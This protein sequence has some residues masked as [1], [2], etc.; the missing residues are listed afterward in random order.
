MTHDDH[1]REQMG[2]PPVHRPS[3][4]Q[5]LEWYQEWR[6]GQDAELI[7][8]S[9]FYDALWDVAWHVGPVWVLI[10]GTHAEHSSIRVGEHEFIEREGEDR[11]I[12]WARRLKEPREANSPRPEPPETT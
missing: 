12:E 11:L 6:A 8:R 5:M 7:R 1:L 10:A 3:D 4:E 2:V 9:D